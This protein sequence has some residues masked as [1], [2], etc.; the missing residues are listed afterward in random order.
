MKAEDWKDVRPVTSS[1]SKSSDY[2][3]TN[4]SM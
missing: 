2:D 1:Q 3:K 4:S